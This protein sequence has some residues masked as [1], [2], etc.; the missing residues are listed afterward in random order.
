MPYTLEL[1]TLSEEIGGLKAKL[2]IKDAELQS[3]KSSND[4]LVGVLKESLRLYQVRLGYSPMPMDRLSTDILMEEYEGAKATFNT[5]F[6][7][8][9]V[10]QKGEVEEAGKS[11]TA[12]LG[13]FQTKEVL[14]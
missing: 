8:G 6:K 5:R 10:S 1:K 11:D 4:K 9:P 13:I 2:Q 14:K 3:A 12:K 7:V